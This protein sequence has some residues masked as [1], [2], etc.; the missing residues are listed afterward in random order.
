MKEERFVH[1]IRTFVRKIRTNDKGIERRK[2]L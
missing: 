2:S 1:K